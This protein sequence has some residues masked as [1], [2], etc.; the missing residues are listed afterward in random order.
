MLLWD[1]PTTLLFR[2]LYS[3]LMVAH[4]LALAVIAAVVLLP[5][6]QYYTTF[7]GGVI[8]VSTV[9]L[10]VVDVFHPSHF[11]DVAQAHV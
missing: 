4:H 8:E 1:L 2:S 7:F 11:V 3:R 6:C 5:C 10:L 9:P